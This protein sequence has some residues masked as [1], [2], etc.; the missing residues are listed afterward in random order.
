[1]TISAFSSNAIASVLYYAQI[2]NLKFYALPSLYRQGNFDRV[3]LYETDIL[4]LAYHYNVNLDQQIKIV[5]PYVLASDRLA[6][7]DIAQDIQKRCRRMQKAQ[8]FQQHNTLEP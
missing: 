3:A 8:A 4:Q 1:M 6:I 7:R 2:F 5:D